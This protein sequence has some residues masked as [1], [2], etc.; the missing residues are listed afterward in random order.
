MPVKTGE[1]LVKSKT[2]NIRN[3]PVRTT[4]AED[5]YLYPL[6]EDFGAQRAW[7]IMYNNGR[8]SDLDYTTSFNF[9]YFTGSL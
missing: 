4:V 2:I 8:T 7:I 1:I 3:S 5:C 6:E 9:C